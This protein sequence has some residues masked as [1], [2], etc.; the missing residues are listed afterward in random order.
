MFVTASGEHSINT[1]TLLHETNSD[2]SS[3]GSS[4]AY[5]DGTS[6]REVVVVPVSSAENTRDRDLVI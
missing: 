5:T 2:S 3:S 6:A 1:E 4:S